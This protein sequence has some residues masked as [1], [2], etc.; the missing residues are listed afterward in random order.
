MLPKITTL[1]TY[2]RI[3]IILQIRLSTEYEKISIIRKY[4]HIGRPDGL[5]PSY[6]KNMDLEDFLAKLWNLLAA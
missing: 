1:L 2:W 4:C 3:E 6:F 5:N